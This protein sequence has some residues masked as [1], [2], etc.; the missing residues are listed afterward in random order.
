MYVGR[1]D[2]IGGVFPITIHSNYQN[3]SLPLIIKHDQELE[4]IENFMVSITLDSASTACGN[5]A[6]G[7]KATIEIEDET[8]KSASNVQYSVGPLVR[9]NLRKVAQQFTFSINYSTFWY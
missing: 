3:A 6:A 1:D 7:D 4:G 9:P 8:G 2:Y 5:I